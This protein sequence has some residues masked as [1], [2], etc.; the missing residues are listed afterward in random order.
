MFDN[1]KTFKFCSKEIEKVMQSE[2][3]YHYLA[4]RQ[5]SWQFIVEKALWWGLLGKV[6]EKC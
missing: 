4:N 2:A 1:A 3:V 5:K 6:S